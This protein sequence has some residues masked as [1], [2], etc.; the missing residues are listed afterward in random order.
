MRRATTLGTPAGGVDDKG[1]PACP[2]PGGTRVWLDETSWVDVAIGWWD[3]AAPLQ[4]RLREEPAWRPGRVWRYD[5]WVTEPR[6]HATDRTAEGDHFGELVDARKELLRAY[7]V[8]LGGG[9]MSRYRDGSD[10]LS[11]HRDTE[12]GYLDETVI[13]ILT[14]G[15]PRPFELKRVGVRENR[16]DLRLMPGSGDLLVMGGRCGADWLHAVPKQPSLGVPDRIS[17]QWR[18]TSGR[19]QPTTSSPYSAPRYF[20]DQVPGRARA[21]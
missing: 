2:L 14:L 18:W 19:G 10:G 3:R 20:T 6:L 1:R 15:G 4:Q 17:V 5:K 7:R 9:G 16:P 21:F 13:A 8:P 12:L 11:F